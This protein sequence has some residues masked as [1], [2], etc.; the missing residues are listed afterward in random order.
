MPST[1]WL[2]FKNAQPSRLST[3]KKAAALW[4]HRLLVR[5]SDPTYLPVL[6]L[7]VQ[8]IR[9]PSGFL[10]GVNTSYC[11]GTAPS[12]LGE[13]FSPCLA[14]AQP[15]SASFLPAQSFNRSA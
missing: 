8:G 9:P 6:Y 5:A 11:I 10:S 14:E 4:S 13:V 1:V 3:N 7:A 12:P 2:N 15:A